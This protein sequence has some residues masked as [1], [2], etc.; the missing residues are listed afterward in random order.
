MFPLSLTVRYRPGFPL[1]FVWAPSLPPPTKSPCTNLRRNPEPHRTTGVLLGKH[2][3]SFLSTRQPGFPRRPFFNRLLVVAV[4]VVEEIFQT[5]ITAQTLDCPTPFGLSWIGGI[6]FRLGPIFWA[7][8]SE[9]PAWN[10]E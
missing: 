1:P 10:P 8:T 4:P 7:D 6:R 3:D 9:S 5:G 2:D